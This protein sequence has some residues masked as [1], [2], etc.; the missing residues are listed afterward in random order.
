M[1]SMYEYDPE[2]KQ[3]RRKRLGDSTE[4][5]PVE[6]SPI[7]AINDKPAA[8]SGDPLP[9]NATRK[10]HER[11]PPPYNKPGMTMGQVL[12]WIIFACLFGGWVYFMFTVFGSA[13]RDGKN[14]T[15]AIESESRD[16]ELLLRSPANI[17][18][19]DVQ[20]DDDELK[21]DDEVFTPPV[22]STPTSDA[23]VSPSSPLDSSFLE[24]DGSSIETNLRALPDVLPDV[25]PAASPER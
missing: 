12:F 17:S 15:K 6:S 2:L 13:H 20:V 3:Y 25:L 14:A 5:T 9:V 1:S 18:V 21:L 11:S 4:D 22:R 24:P 8:L 19:E 23:V 7:A 10:T 16:F